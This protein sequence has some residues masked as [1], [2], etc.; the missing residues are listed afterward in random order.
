M[1][2]L[3]EKGYVINNRH[4]LLLTEK[5]EELARRV[6]ERHQYFKKLL[7]LAGVKEETADHEACLLEHVLSE[8]SYEKL[9]NIWR[10]EKGLRAILF[11]MLLW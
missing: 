10:K 1:K 2:V 7:M 3:E 8:D 5:G 4:S 11:F 9:K 6:Y